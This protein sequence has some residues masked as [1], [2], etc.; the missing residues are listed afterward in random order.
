MMHHPTADPGSR[1]RGRFFRRVLLTA[2]A[3]LLAALLFAS[4][5][6]QTFICDHCL[7]EKTERPHETRVKSSAFADG[8][9]M[10]L[11]AQ[12]FDSYQRGEWELP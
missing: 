10:T 9:T 6:E 4:C 3:A 5:G 12:C 8:V 11:C 1:T 7:Q 2:A